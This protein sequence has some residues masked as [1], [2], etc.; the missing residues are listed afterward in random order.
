MGQQLHVPH[1]EVLADGKKCLDHVAHDGFQGV[2]MEET[3]DG[4]QEHDEGEERKDDVGGDTEGIRMYLSS[5]H[6]SRKS[7]DLISQA[8][9]DNC[10]LY[11]L[12]RLWQLRAGVIDFGC[13]GFRGA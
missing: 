13:V 1:D 6:I 4:Q 3:A 7:D 9:C 2:G 12:K 8:I 11:L 5:G 10:W